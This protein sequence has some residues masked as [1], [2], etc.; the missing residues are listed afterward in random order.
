MGR[1]KTTSA[2]IAAGKEAG[3]IINEATEKAF[4]QKV[5]KYFRSQRELPL[6]RDFRWNSAKDPVAEKKFRDNFDSIFPDS[7]GA[8]I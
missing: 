8:G 3:K 2:E 1:R 5:E 6:G 7:P 4:D